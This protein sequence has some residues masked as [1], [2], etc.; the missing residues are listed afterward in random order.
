M[1]YNVTMRL[2]RVTTVGMEKQYALHIL[3]V[4]LCLNYPAC[5][6]HAVYYAVICDL[7]DS[8]IFFH[9]ILYTARFSAK[10]Y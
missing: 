3:S 1:Y 9:I 6:A 7:S 5:K 2:V 10:S 4:C 8:T